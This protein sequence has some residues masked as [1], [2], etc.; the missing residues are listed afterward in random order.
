MPVDARTKLPTTSKSS[1]PEDE[2]PKTVGVNGMVDRVGEA[3]F[4]DVVAK[5]AEAATELVDTIKPVLGSRGPE[6]IGPA[7]GHLLAILIAGHSP[8]MRSEVMQMVL[9]VANNMIPIEID[10]MIDDGMVGEDWR[11][12]KQ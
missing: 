12:A 5:A 11:G 3:M 10:K 2:Q 1:I 9:D 4:E 6:V 8:D 7:L